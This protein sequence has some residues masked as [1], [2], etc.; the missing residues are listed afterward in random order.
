M[1]ITKDMLLSVQARSCLISIIQ[2]R[3]K[4]SPNNVIT[5]FDDND[6]FQV[7]SDLITMFEVQ[8]H[9]PK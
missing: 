6:A 8:G 3:I 5:T 1:N 9:L 2:K 4:G 7:M